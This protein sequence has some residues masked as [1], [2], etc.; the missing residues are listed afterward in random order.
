MCSMNLKTLIKEPLWLAVSNTYES[1]NYTHSILDAIHYLSGVLR[2][3][4]GLDGDGQSLVGAAL[5]GSSPVLRVNKLQTETE[6]NIQRGL[7]QML[8]GMYQ[9]IRNPRSHEQVEDSK[10]SADAIILFIDYVLGILEQSQEPF[11]IQSFLERVFDEHFVHSA[12]YA[13][14]LVS[15]IPNGKIVDT[16]IEIYRRKREGDGT[17]LSYIT[18]EIFKHVSDEQVGTFLDVVS[19]EFKFR[20]KEIDIRLTLHMLVPD[21]WRKLEE[22]ARLRAENILINSIKQGKSS[23]GGGTIGGQGA[24]G[25][26]ARDYLVEFSQKNQAQQ[27]ILEKLEAEEEDQWYIYNFFLLVLPALFDIS[28]QKSR[29]LKAVLGAAKN[30]LGDSMSRKLADNFWRFPKNWQDA[31]RESFPESE[32][33]DEMPF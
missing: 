24:L 21:L 9:F 15:S 29:C 33:E 7:E 3:K 31:I 19:E 13:E 30:E 23:S 26:W 8:R 11:T 2:E 6:R 1:E 17:N 4:S 22:S 20:T 25:T 32:I 14:L 5:G 18:K 10:N 27:L 16:L 28:Y 12:R